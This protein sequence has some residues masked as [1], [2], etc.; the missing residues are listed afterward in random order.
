MHTAETKISSVIELAKELI[1]CP[2]ITPNDTGCLKI[3]SNRLNCVGFECES[4]HFG[5]VDNLWARYGKHSP[6]I[7][8]AGHTDVVPLGPESNWTSLP[9]QPEIRNGFL[10]GRGASDMKGAIAAMIITVEKFVKEHPHFPGSIAFLMTSDEEGPSVDG[11]KK[12]VEVLQKRG[13]KINYCIIGEPSSDAHLGD[14]IRIGRRGSLHGKLTIHGKQGHVAHPHLAKNPIHLS[15]P[16]LHQLAQTEWDK[17]NERFPQTTFQITHIH[18]GTGATNVIP[19]HL[20]VLFNFR[21]S[22]AV[23]VK[24]LQERTEKILHK[25]GLDFHITWEIGGEPFLTKKGQLIDATQQAIKEITHLDTKLSTGGGTSDGR[26]IAPTGA[27]VVELGVSHAT[28]HHVN[29][30]VRVEDLEILTKIY[31]KLLT[32]LLPCE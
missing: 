12:V 17:G 20:D 5:E 8:F 7:V 13:V 2:S 21:F 24:Q 11:T 10:Y 4:M 31:S 9:F 27:E 18:S 30:Y 15:M 14:Q 6:L 19:G 23:T 16:A 25:H 1:S 32:I 3:I 22:T 29:E 28:A 26:F